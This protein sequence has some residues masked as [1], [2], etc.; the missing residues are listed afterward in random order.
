VLRGNPSSPAVWNN[1]GNALAA[2]GRQ[3]EALASYDKA[4]ALAPNHP[5]LLNHRAITLYE[6]KRYEEAARDFAAALKADPRHPY[7]LGN[8]VYAK[9]HCCDWQET[10]EAR[11]EIAKRVQAGEETITPIQ[12]TALAIS[13]EEQYLCSRRWTARKY[14]A[15]A[16]LWKGERYAHEKIRVAYLSA[17]FHSHAT[18]ALMAGVFEH[19]DRDR[20]ET[21]AISYGMDDKSEMR[22]RLKAA[23]DRFIDVRDYSDPAAAKLLRQSEIDIAVDLKGYTQEARLGILAHRP[24][25]VHATYLGFPGTLGADYIDYAIVDRIV[26][27]PEHARWYSEKL[28]YLPD[29]YQCNDAKRAISDRAISRADAGLPQTG[30]VFCSF[31]NSFKI[32]PEIFDIWMRLLCAVE[33]SVLWLLD[34]NAAAV[35][36]L[37]REAGARGVAGARLVFA[38]RADLDYH[39]ARHRLADLFLDTLPYGAHTTASDALWAGVPVLTCLGATFP[40]RVAASLLQAVGLP[41]LIVHSLADYEALALDLARNPDRLAA[42][43]AKLAGNRRTF[44]LFDSARFTRHLEAAFTAM[45]ER[46]ERGEPPAAFAITP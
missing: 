11:A 24:A 20:F 40:G 30:F 41:E 39:L 1:R 23:F 25:P 6:L 26:A 32:A 17:D 16:P 13:P 7:A 12:F 29:T 36:N 5:G 22:A 42:I 27:P 21:Y 18:A 4:L 37:R 31:N 10:E 44:P 3:T 8:L 46:A 2:L 9:R 45:R 14:P 28:V 35:R 38:P 33:G 34:D 19:H 43:K 15:V